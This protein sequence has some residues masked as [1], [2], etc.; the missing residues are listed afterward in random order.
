MGTRR[1]KIAQEIREGLGQGVDT[2]SVWEDTENEL[3][4]GTEII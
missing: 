3:G 2:R 4:V 1:E